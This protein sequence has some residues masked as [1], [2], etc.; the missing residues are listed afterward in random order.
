MSSGHAIGRKGDAAKRAAARSSVLAA[1]GLTGFKL[2]VGMLTGSLGILAEAA[3]SGLDLVAAAMT[4][5]AVS[6]SGRPPDSEHRYG[7]GKVE[8]LSAF[9]ETLLLLA[10]CVWI[11]Y[12]SVNRLFFHPVHVD[13]SPWAFAVMVVSILVDVSRSRLLS[14]VAIEYN[15]QAL[16]A[17]ALH[18]STD[19]WS[20]AV[21]LVGLV[22]VVTADWVPRL[23]WLGNADA[24]AALGVAVIVVY[25]SVEL[26]SRTVRALLDTAPP[27]LDGK[28][29][30]AVRAV[31]GVTDCHQLRMRYS[32]AQL[33]VDIHVLTDGTQTLQ[34]AH[35]L[36][37]RIEDAISRI[38]PDADVT[39]HPEPV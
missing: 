34:Q 19:I 11:I 33:F 6:V 12:E 8:N 10:T 36:T 22:G 5:W 38:V 25:I 15:S 39:V 17:D 37:D 32:G 23:A 18:F 29:I 7:H 21:V 1:I 28:L 31:P 24:V 20:S 16:E 30:A 13:A 2:V 35:D 14:R 4:Y 3:H 26:G 27:D 9:A